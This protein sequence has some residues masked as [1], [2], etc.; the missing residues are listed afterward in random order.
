VPHQE[1]ASKDL[2][3]DKRAD[4]GKKEDDALKEL[5]KAIQELEKRLRQ[6]REEEAMRQLA[7]LEARC[8]RMIQLQTA[9][10]EA[11][12]AID[13]GVQKAGGQKGTADIQKA[14]TQADR[15]RE[16][17]TEA[18]KTLDLLKAEGSAV[19]FAGVLQEVRSD[20]A[21]VQKRLTD[22]D[23]GPITQEVEAN[24]IALLKEMAAALK[25]QQQEMQQQ[26][27]QQ[28]QQP[29]SGP[30]PNQALVN[31]IAELKL[32]R[33]LQVQVNSRTKLLGGKT[34]GEQTDDPKLAAELRA[35]AARQAKI[36][37]MLTALATG[38]N[39]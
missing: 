34:P 3:K 16:I 28:Q 15:E 11:T 20:M 5:N 32:I 12:K 22:A 10:Y 13:A 18:D 27:Q 31:K 19:A 14:Q 8:N 36:E 6:L 9:V 38:A 7:G 1:G 30:Q 29:Q 26:Q 23:V 37:E 33:S 35:L 4:A 21:G 24:I 39:Q 25:K 17:V 2:E